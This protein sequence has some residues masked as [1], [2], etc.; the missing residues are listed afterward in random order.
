MRDPEYKPCTKCSEYRIFSPCEIGEFLA[1]DFELKPINLVTREE[2]DTSP[3][4]PDG[5]LDHVLSSVLS[6]RHISDPVG[7]IGT[8]RGLE[9]REGHH[10]SWIALTYGFNL[11]A[12]IF[13]PTCGICK[14]SLFVDSMNAWTRAKGWLYHQQGFTR[15]P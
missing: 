13:T 2:L 15:T 1:R 3:G 11:S 6:T 14:E 8:G 9:I 10:R 7:L 4:S 5:W 12:Y